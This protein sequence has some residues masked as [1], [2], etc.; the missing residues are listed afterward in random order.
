MSVEAKVSAMSVFKNGK[1]FHCEF[2]R[3]GRRRCSSTGTTTK[4]QAIAK[5]RRQRERLE[6]SYRFPPLLAGFIFDDL[7]IQPGGIG[8]AS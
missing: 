6:K 2:I 4:Q 1:F 5:E 7:A 3:D 8:L